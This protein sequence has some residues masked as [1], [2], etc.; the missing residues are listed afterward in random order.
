MHFKKRLVWAVLVVLFVTPKLDAF[1]VQVGSFFEIKDLRIKNGQPVLPLV[2]NKYS[3]IRILDQETFLW[4][5]QACATEK[6]CVQPLTQM[7]V[8]VEQVKM[9]G[10]YAD[11]WW[12]DVSFSGKWQVTF[13]V[14]KKGADVGIV[15]PKKFKFLTQPFEE[16]VRQKIVAYIL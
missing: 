15:A 2:K 7:D 14:F 8:H 12:A 1:T 4:V 6:R 13:L 9:L 11:E 16:A 3:D 5:Q 10:A